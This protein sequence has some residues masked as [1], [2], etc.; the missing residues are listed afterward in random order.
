MG[1]GRNHSRARADFAGKQNH[2]VESF[3]V[4]SPSGAET[5]VASKAAAIKDKGYEGAV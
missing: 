5:P 3:V 2:G 4:A 1:T